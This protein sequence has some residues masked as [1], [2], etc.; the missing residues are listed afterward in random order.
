MAHT[1]EPAIILY[2]LVTVPLLDPVAIQ[3]VNL[4]LCQVYTITFSHC[5][6]PTT[7]EL[8]STITIQVFYTLPYLILPADFPLEHYCNLIQLV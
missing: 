6:D 3:Y 5:L 8:H 4:V 7:L 1:L 2:N